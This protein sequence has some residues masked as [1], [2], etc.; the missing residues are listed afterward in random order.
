MTGKGDFMPLNIIVY[1]L[2]VAAT[3]VSAVY[4]NNKLGYTPFFFLL[5]LLIIDLLYALFA[6]IGLTIVIPTDECS[7]TRDIETEFTVCFQNSGAYY[8][9]HLRAELKMCGEHL[10]KPHF[11]S[12]SFSLSPHS[13]STTSFPIALH[14]LGVYTINI[15]KIKVYD[16]LGIFCFKIKPKSSRTLWCYPKIE[17]FSSVGTVRNGEIQNAAPLFSSGQ[18]SEFYNGVREYVPGDSM[19]SIHWK[20]SAHTRKYMT[21]LYESDDAGGLVVLTDLKMA[22]LPYEQKLALNDV[23]I[24]SAV[25]V[26]NSRVLHGGHARVI[27]ADGIELKASLINSPSDIPDLSARLICANESEFDIGELIGAETTISVVICTANVDMDLACQLADIKSAG[28]LPVL[29]YA[30]PENFDIESKHQ[31]FEFLD[32]LDIEYFITSAKAGEAA[33]SA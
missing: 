27:Y 2:S 18:N 26:A 3:A 14:H 13:Q 24:E 6:L 1:I 9:P 17:G 29:I 10:D 32:K 22:D 7:A 4:F 12:K 21:R 16:F 20:L 23:V 31:L 28:G 8:L 5:C 15:S 25:S 19:H 11:T 30:V 33:I